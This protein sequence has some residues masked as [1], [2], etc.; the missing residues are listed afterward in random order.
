MLLRDS[1]VWQGQR[2][3]PRYVTHCEE[4]GM[5]SIIAIVVEQIPN[6]FLVSQTL[7]WKN[8]TEFKLNKC[9]HK[10]NIEYVAHI[11]KCQKVGW[12]ALLSKTDLD[13]TSFR[14]IEGPT[15]RKWECILFWDARYWIQGLSDA[16]QT[17]SH[18]A[19]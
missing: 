16:Q 13:N 7:C 4:L 11:C 8:Q 17:R 12:P 15:G 10:K 5:V 6:I 9:M 1:S 14:V 3:S 18:W 19:N 2:N